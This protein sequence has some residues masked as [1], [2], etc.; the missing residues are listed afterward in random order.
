[1]QPVRKVLGATHFKQVLL[2][3]ANR[4]KWT[5]CSPGDPEA[6]EKAWTDIDSDELLEPPLKLADFERALAGARPTV[7]QEDIQKHTQWTNDAG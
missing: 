4:P 1:M 5:P 7:T 2:S 3:D 6:V